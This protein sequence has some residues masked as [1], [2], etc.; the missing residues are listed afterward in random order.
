MRSNRRVAR[1]RIAVCFCALAASAASAV[2]LA[3]A[4]DYTGVWKRN[5]ED[6]VALHIKRVRERVYSIS[7]CNP[8]GCTPPG[9]Y[10]PNSP[11]DADP[12]YQVLAPGR[13]RVK[14]ADGGYAA[15]LKCSAD[16]NP[17]VLGRQ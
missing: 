7:F 10:R 11:I 8:D 14:D 13:I 17:P 12:G 9:K 5:C 15:Y 4:V 3:Q 1:I 2:V 6:P 16:P